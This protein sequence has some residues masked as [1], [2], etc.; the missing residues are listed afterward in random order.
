MTEPNGGGGPL[1][2]GRVGSARLW[3]VAVALAALIWVARLAA[4]LALPGGAV[5]EPVNARLGAAIPLL[6]A[7]VMFW[8]AARVRARRAPAG[9]WWLLAAA[10]LCY[11]AGE[12]PYA[13]FGM[14]LTQGPLA[15][16]GTVAYL[17]FY[18]LFLAA[19]LR[20]PA[21]P[22]QAH[23][24]LKLA[25]DTGIVLAAAGLVEWTLLLEPTVRR[26]G[27]DPIRVVLTGAFP[28]GDLL[29][30]WALLEI[31]LRRREPGT[32]PVHVLLAGAA[33]LLIVTDVLWGR[34]L[35]LFDT[36]Y[37]WALGPGWAASH[38]LAGLAA[39]WVVA[40]PRPSA[41][42]VAEGH[43]ESASRA[44][45][46][47]A[48]ACVGVAAAVLVFR[49]PR[50]A[51]SVSTWIAVGVGALV[52]VRHLLGM[53]EGSRLN[54]QLRA[55]NENLESKV[56]KRTG[57]LNQ[58]NAELLA[59]V[60]EHRRT[61]EELRRRLGELILLSAV[62]EIAVE[63]ADEESLLARTTLAVRGALFADGCAVWLV[64]EAEQALEIP[65]AFDTGFAPDEAKRTP[66]GR[67][68]AGEVAL[69]G[70]ARRVAGADDAAGT[71]GETSPPSQVCVPL[72][73]GD[74][75]AG[76]IEVRSHGSCFTE[77]DERVLATVASQVATA[78]ERLRAA[79]ALRH[80]EQNY[81]EVFNATSEAIFI[82]DADTGAILEVNQT[83][84]DLFGYT[85]EEALALNV[86]D[87]SAQRRPFTQEEAVGRIRRA[88][89]AG[90]QAFEWRSRRQGGAE[91]W[92]EVTLR[93]ALIGGHERVLAVVRDISD[94]KRAEEAL[95]LSEERFRSMVQQ[96]Y[97]FITILD[98]KGTITYA[99]PTAGRA[100]GYGT[101]GLIGR[102]GFELIH[103]D[104]LPVV[105]EAFQRTIQGT[106]T[107]RPIE[108]RIRHAGG[109][110]V[111]LEALGSN[112]LD[113]P[114]INGILLNVREIGERKRAELEIRRKL[115]ELTV[116][117]AVAELIVGAEDEG[118]L[119]GR[120]TEIVR[121]ALY[122]DDCG[123]LLVDEAARVLR[124]TPSYRQDTPVAS[125]EPIPLEAGIT[126]SVA[127]TGVARREGD[128]ARVPEYVA[129]LAGMRSEV[130]VPMKVGDRVIGVINAES[131]RADAFTEHDEDVLQ[132]A[133]GQLATAIGRLRAAAAQEESRRRIQRQL[134][135]L[136]AL[137]AI[138]AAITGGLD[139][140]AMLDLFLDHLLTQLG[141]DA[142][143]ILLL[144]PAAAA[145]LFSAEKGFLSDAVR[146]TR[147]ELGECCAG[148]AA[149]NRR[150]IV[151]ADV[152]ATPDGSARGALLA[153]E[154]FKV[155]FAAPL[156]AKGR[157]HG[158][159]EVFHRRPSEPDREWLDYLET[160]AGQ[161]AIAIDN[162]TL[163]ESLER[164]NAE[165]A[166]AYDTTLEGWSKALEL[167]DRET[168][169]HTGRV[170]DLSVRLATTMGLATEDLV[171]VRRGA[172]LHDIGKMA[173]PDSI[174]LKPG[175]LTDDEWDV[176]RQ[177]PQFAFDLLS[178]IGFL[179]SAIA[180][181]Y[182]H[183]EH[184]DGSG[185]PRG[186]AGT[187]IP[188]VAR[189][190]AVV[191][192][193]DALCSDRPY[194]RAWKEER[195]RAYLREEAGR[196]F[197]PDVV[198]TFLAMAGQ[199]GE[200]PHRRREA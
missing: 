160:L 148:R 161:L 58:A 157:V 167:R 109:A 105:R 27:F 54:L 24:R 35:L 46:Y 45:M 171:H 106:T 2:R 60:G 170:V 72:R 9:A 144:E 1:E 180:I 195:V 15:H 101:G 51:V 95:N 12:V 199:D 71:T 88:I 194:R 119:I 22:L 83:T 181:P 37:D 166:Q 14:G 121:G 11:A 62:A 61:E 200:P 75:V 82:H 107:G 25:L 84:L 13:V 67:G 115:D 124:Y 36:A 28:V 114:S 76:V 134:E 137:R 151:I 16:A 18:V 86:V 135:R 155:C 43:G 164:S 188:L 178:P 129:R 34:R 20:L 126:G 169:G 103:P 183:H 153:A 179:R 89:E 117:N 133:A 149:L 141:A 123:V 3:P 139:L 175:P 177:H 64:N 17:L 131:G 191:D 189:I 197:D 38:L 145:L 142:A 176:M 136:G 4:Q 99:T 97:D 26:P 132:T 150:T 55:A 42:A 70:T 19:A 69:A 143:D 154:G 192:A 98:A 163:F 65:P 48:D 190:F 104:D 78:I 102:S 96:S 85:R 56:R 147:L 182:S 44:S 91:F 40:R 10:Y 49:E 41:P 74:R 127:S 146:R 80:S 94:R 100:L 6:V 193:W 118:A 116:L 173:I 7:I 186:L 110:W 172:L 39:V 81:R 120:V 128:L 5:S 30:L 122:P 187:E 198:E 29:L 130:C 184:W 73:V 93:R 57:E 63:A 112:Q 185:Y 92:T 59:E 77:D 8:A 108:F 111:F 79:E 47:L 174:L 158:V 87:L 125:R 90:P 68:L 138:D 23:E 32:R 152:E 50:G 196:R 52:T 165:L 33:A 159:L 140:P 21:A 156:I 66:F 168:H 53:H 31:L 162:R 113:R